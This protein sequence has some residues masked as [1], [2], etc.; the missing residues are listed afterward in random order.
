MRL[1]VVLPEWLSRNQHR[2]DYVWRRFIY[3]RL[4]NLWGRDLLHR[5][6]CNFHISK[7]YEHGISTNNWS[8]RSLLLEGCRVQAVLINQKVH[9]LQCFNLRWASVTCNTLLLEN[10]HKIQFISPPDIYRATGCER[11]WL[12]LQLA[13]RICWRVGLFFK[14]RNGELCFRT[15]QRHMG[16]QRR[17]WCIFFLYS[18]FV[19]ADPNGFY[20]NLL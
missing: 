2:N 7:P 15:P 13:I 5:A 8:D 20:R 9:Y 12:L 3:S 11:S 18:L 1:S 19:C 4:F 6:P 14:L 17:R 10:L 16:I